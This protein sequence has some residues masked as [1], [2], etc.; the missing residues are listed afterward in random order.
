MST[1]TSTRF[2][3]ATAW[4]L[5]QIHVLCPCLSD[6]EAQ[7][8]VLQGHRPLGAPGRVL[9]SYPHPTSETLTSGGGATGTLAPWHPVWLRRRLGR[10]G[11]K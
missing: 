2:Q 1:I 7:G 5:G 3:P 8:P 4:P 6:K 9:P 11:P 10:A